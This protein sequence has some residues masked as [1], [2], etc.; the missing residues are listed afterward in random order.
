[1]NTNIFEIYQG[2]D[3][4]IFF[5]A[6]DSID[7]PVN[8]TQIDISVA[9][10]NNFQNKIYLTEQTEGITLIKDTENSFVVSIVAT[11]TKTLPAGDYSMSVMLTKDGKKAIE[12]I[13]I[14]R[15]INSLHK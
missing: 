12:Q 4:E 6:K 1:M 5:S 3:I 9:F 13:K 14:I 8:I 7:K 10:I 15:I 11:T 2:E